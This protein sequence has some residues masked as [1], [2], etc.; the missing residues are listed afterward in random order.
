LP[1]KLADVA[2]YFQLL[3]NF[4]KLGLGHLLERV[5][6]LGNADLTVD[7][8]EDVAQIPR[9]IAGLAGRLLQALAGLGEYRSAMHAR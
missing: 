5:Q 4:Q 8:L 9:Q 6:K 3:E 2:L 7:F 1:D